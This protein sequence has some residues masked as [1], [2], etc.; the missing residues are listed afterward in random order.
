MG[1]IGVGNAVNASTPGTVVRKMEVF[2]P[3]GTGLGF[4][5]IYSAIS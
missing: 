1:G 3:T 2:S 4:V 5:P